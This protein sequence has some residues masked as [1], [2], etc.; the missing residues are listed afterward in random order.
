M[1]QED[2]EMKSRIR[3]SRFSMRDYRFAV[4][5][6]GKAFVDAALCLCPSQLIRH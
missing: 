4:W 2:K 6:S 1:I 5:A 3:S